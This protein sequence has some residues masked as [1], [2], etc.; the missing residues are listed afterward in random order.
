[1]LVVEGFAEGPAADTG[2]GEHKFDPGFEFYVAVVEF[3][4]D[5]AM[6]LVLVCLEAMR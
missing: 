2:G 4:G 5:G 1:M 6:K 3:F